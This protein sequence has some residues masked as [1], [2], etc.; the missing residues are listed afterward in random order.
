ML[1]VPQDTPIHRASISE[2]SD[3]QLDKLIES[4]RERRMRSYTLFQQAQQAKAEL[5]EQKDKDRYEHLMK[6]AEKKLESVDKGLEALSKYV[7]EMR[8]IQLVLGGN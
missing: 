5:K 6:M 8:A 3:E 7:N 2:L 1:P 4:M